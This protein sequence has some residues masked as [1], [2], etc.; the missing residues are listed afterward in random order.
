MTTDQNKPAIP[1]RLLVY[2]RVGGP[3]FPSSGCLEQKSVGD[4]TWEQ[5]SLEQR[6][7]WQKASRPA[8]HGIKD[9]FL[10]MR[11]Q[12]CGFFFL[13]MLSSHSK[14]RRRVSTD[15]EGRFSLSLAVVLSLEPTLSR[16][17]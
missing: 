3:V 13:W 12:P 7:V 8:I 6:V 11:A 9:A 16:A 14:P 1:L 5:R 17:R 10:N 4:E 15:R 2:R